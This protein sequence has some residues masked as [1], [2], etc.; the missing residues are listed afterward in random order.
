[1]PIGGL[2]PANF[3]LFLD[4]F[5]IDSV[6]QEIEPG[7][8]GQNPALQETRQSLLKEARIDDLPPA[9]HKEVALAELE[10]KAAAR[11]DRKARVLQCS[12]KFRR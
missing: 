11:K 4:A 1:M 9:A 7:P 2:A 6:A 12:L 10:I 5:Y 3:S 8:A